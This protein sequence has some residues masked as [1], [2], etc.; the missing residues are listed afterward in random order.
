MSDR[1]TISN[2]GDQAVLQPGNGAGASRPLTRDQIVQRLA[3]AAEYKRAARVAAEIA[4]Q[5]D[6]DT[7]AWK[8]RTV[9]VLRSWLSE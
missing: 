6:E 3:K 7:D 8:E 5:K 9:N 4:G 2:W 1:K